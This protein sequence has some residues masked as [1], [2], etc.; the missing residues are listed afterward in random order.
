MILPLSLLGDFS[1]DLVSTAA[2]ALFSL[3]LCEQGLYQVQTKQPLQ[4]FMWLS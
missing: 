4:I 3:I 1:P 2:D